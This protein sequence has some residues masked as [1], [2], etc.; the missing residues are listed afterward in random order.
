MLLNFE[1][2]LTPV[3]DTDTV[4][5]ET[6]IMLREEN[7]TA[8]AP[9]LYTPEKILDVTNA[10]CNETYT[11]GKDWFLLE[12]GSFCLTPESRIFA[13]TRAE[14]YPTQPIPGNSFPMP[15]GNLLFGEGSMFHDRKICI[16][17]TVKACDWPGVT[18]VSARDRLPHTFAALDSAAPLHILLYGDSIS[19]GGNASL[20]IAADPYQ[21]P[22]GELFGVGM[23]RR[24]ASPI[25]F[26]NTAVGGR[27]TE[28]G[29]RWAK[30]LVNSYAPD[31]VLLAFGMNDACKTPEE[32]VANT[33]K[34]I[35][36]I[37]ADKPETEFVLIATSTPNP[38]LT[39]E[40]ARFVG[41]Q[42]EY[43]A[44]LDALAADE[45]LG[46]G[47]AVADITGMQAALHSRKRFL[48]TTGNH[49]N[50]PDDF[51]HRLYAQYLMGMFPAK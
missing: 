51:F 45:A 44:A 12:D 35:E 7:G 31:L 19:A 11:E 50:H 49:V 28:W 10:A 22:F 24:F 3:W 6:L 5:N 29:I 46:G 13:F 21:P 20:Y 4:W 23:S 16:S 41:H 25:R 8:A 33:R 1:Q 40:R 43:K 27:E 42:A 39:D 47:I 36:I 17:Y 38:I 34:I 32:F 2:M 48:D 30:H 26:T 15:D 9:L 18:P 37:R 14:L